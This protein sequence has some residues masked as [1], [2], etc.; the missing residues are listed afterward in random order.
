[1]VPLRSPRSTRPVNPEPEFPS[2]I[3]YG[4]G[5]STERQGRD[6]CPE[7]IIVWGSHQR[8]VVV[9]SLERVGR[10]FKLG[11]LPR[12]FLLENHQIC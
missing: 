7:L 10:C 2:V 3:R 12:D 6:A 11:Q 9:A 1:M 8:G 4:A 5:W